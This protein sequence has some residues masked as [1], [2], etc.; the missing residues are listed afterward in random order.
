M[1]RKIIIVTQSDSHKKLKAKFSFPLKIP[2]VAEVFCSLKEMMTKSAD[3]YFSFLYCDCQD[4]SSKCSQ[5]A[6][7]HLKVLSA[8]FNIIINFQCFIT[9][10]S[11]YDSKTY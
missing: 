5:V 3:L 2:S 6:D 10:K 4:G 1:N 11:Y 9:T 8:I 7:T